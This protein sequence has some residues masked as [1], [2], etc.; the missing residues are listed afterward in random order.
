LDEHP[1]YLQPSGENNVSEGFKI[2]STAKKPPKIAKKAKK[3][4]FQVK[5]AYVKTTATVTFLTGTCS[6]SRFNTF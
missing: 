6:R 2:K 1:Y 5:D 3:S 4:N